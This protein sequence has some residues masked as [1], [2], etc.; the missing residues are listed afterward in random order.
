[1]DGSITSVEVVVTEGVESP[2]CAVWLISKSVKK[3]SGWTLLVYCLWMLRARSSCFGWHWDC[4]G[5]HYS[6]AHTS[7]PMSFFRSG[8][9]FRWRLL[10][11]VYTGFN[12]PESDCFFAS[13]GLNG[14][15]THHT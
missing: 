13:R 6:T 3:R 10:Q 9:L 1:M 4:W 14:Y 7:S 11:P 15:A 5:W 12:V 2:T 8:R